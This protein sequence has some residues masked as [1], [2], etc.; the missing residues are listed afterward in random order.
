MG[1]T[2]KED[3]HFTTTKRAIMLME[4]ILRLLVMIF[5][6]FVAV[7]AVFG[8]LCMND[9]LSF[10]SLVSSHSEWFTRCT[11]SIRTASVCFCYLRQNSFLHN[12]FLSMNKWELRMLY[13]SSNELCT[14]FFHPRISMSNMHILL[15]RS[16]KELGTINLQ[17]QLFHVHWMH[18]F[19]HGN[20]F[21]ITLLILEYLS[22]C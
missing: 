7:N 2:V 11:C 5:F 10:C 12:D 22:V 8:L 19:I 13:L 1:G 14:I 16:F 15:S 18:E 17:S 4:S 20:L 9:M 3:G 6:S 21:G